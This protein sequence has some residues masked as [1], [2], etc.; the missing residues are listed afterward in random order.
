VA[1]KH[2]PGSR[3][4]MDEGSMIV[5]NSRRKM[6]CALLRATAYAVER[7]IRRMMLLALVAE[8]MVIDVVAHHTLRPDCRK[9]VASGEAAA[10]PYHERW[11]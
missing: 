7:M 6:D 5:M 8:G 9:M 1:M 3:M 10:V 2:Q 4:P 11:A